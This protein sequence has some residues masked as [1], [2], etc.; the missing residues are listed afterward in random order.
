MELYCQEDYSLF[1]IAQLQNISRQGVRDA[2][3]RAERTLMRM[4]EQLQFASRHAALVA[5]LRSIEKQLQEKGLQDDAQ[6]IDTL[7]KEWEG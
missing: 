4:E 2:L 5:G 1:E 3:M 7:L 6:R